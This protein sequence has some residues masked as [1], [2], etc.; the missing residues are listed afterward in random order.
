MKHTN[1]HTQDP[2]F[3]CY[4][5]HNHARPY[6]RSWQKTQGKRETIV[7][8]ND[9]RTEVFLPGTS[10]CLV[11]FLHFSNSSDCTWGKTWGRI[12]T[13]K[14]DRSFFRLTL[15]HHFPSFKVSCQPAGQTEPQTQ[16]QKVEMNVLADSHVFCSQT[17]TNWGCF[18][19]ATYQQ[20]DK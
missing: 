1:T 13:D 19:N 3:M 16:I 11:G 5:K 4:N 17:H 10:S 15:N 9:E 8:L 20:E 18:W 14:E 12:C 7:L 2:V 6:V